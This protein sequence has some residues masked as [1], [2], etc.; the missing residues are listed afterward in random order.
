MDSYAT[1]PVEK[2]LA[3]KVRLVHTHGKPSEEATE[4]TTWADHHLRGVPL[5]KPVKAELNFTRDSVAAWIDRKWETVPAKLE[6]GKPIAGIPA[7]T[8]AYYFSDISGNGFVNSTSITE[9]SHKT[10]EIK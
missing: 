9:T 1:V 5:P 6:N 4:L 8:T 7:G 3:L 2:S 10:K